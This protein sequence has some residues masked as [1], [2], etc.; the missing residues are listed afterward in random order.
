[1]QNVIHLE[2]LFIVLGVALFPAGRARSLATCAAIRSGLALAGLRAGP[3]EPVA[4]LPPG[5]VAVEGALLGIGGVLA[6]GSALA[7]VRSA[8]TSGDSRG[9]RG[10]GGRRARGGP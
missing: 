2:F 6:L 5:F 1:M 9:G 4:T 8:R 7:A 3:A 10:R